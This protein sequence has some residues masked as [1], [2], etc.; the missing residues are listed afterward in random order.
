MAAPTILGFSFEEVA[1]PIVKAEGGQLLAALQAFIAGLTPQTVPLTPTKLVGATS[2]MVVTAKLSESDIYLYRVIGEM[3]E[4]TFSFT[5]LAV[6]GAAGSIL[7]PLPDGFMTAPYGTPGTGIW[8]VDAG[9]AQAGVADARVSNNYIRI[10]RSVLG[11]WTDTAGAFNTQI[12]GQ[13]A[14]PIVRL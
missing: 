4:L 3:M 5:Q 8:V 13:L 1:D 7:L 11:N 9:T 2:A 6:A 14:V 10:R 12:K